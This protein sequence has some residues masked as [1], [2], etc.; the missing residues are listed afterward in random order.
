M[1]SGGEVDQADAE[2]RAKIGKVKNV[3]KKKG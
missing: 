1:R 3:I 2:L